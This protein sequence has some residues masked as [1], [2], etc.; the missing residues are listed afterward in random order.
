M[1]TRASTSQKETKIEMTSNLKRIEVPKDAQEMNC[2][3]TKE[4]DKDVVDNQSTHGVQWTRRRVKLLVLVLALLVVGLTIALVVVL[5]DKN[6]SDDHS[7]RYYEWE[8]LGREISFNLGDAPATVHFTADG[9]I[10]AVHEH[11]PNTYDSVKV[12][13]LSEVDYSY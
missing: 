6:G 2:D 3:E 7:Q 1:R 4:E 9:S 10:L 11:N 13:K 12:Y 8:Q 5:L